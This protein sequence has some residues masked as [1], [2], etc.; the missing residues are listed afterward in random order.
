[1]AYGNT[2]QSLKARIER[3]EKPVNYDTKYLNIDHYQGDWWSGEAEEDGGTGEQEG[4][5]EKSTQ[6]EATQDQVNVIRVSNINNPHQLVIW[7]LIQY[8][9]LI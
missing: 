3:T 8:N 4:E 7:N 1:M 9:F 2:I 5:E 6:D